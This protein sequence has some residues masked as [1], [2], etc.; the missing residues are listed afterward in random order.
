[1]TSTRFAVPLSAAL[2]ELSLAQEVPD[3]R[4]LDTMIRRYPE[5]SE[6]LTEFAIGLA[7]NSLLDQTE[8]E[9]CESVAESDELNAW[10][11]RAMSRFQNRLYSVRMGGTDPRVEASRLQG[12]VPNPFQRLDRVGFR[13]LASKLNANTAFVIKLRDRQILPDTVPDG[14]R[15][16]VE[17]ELDIPEG[18][19][20]GHLSA[21]S[22]LSL[23][24]QFFKAQNKPTFDIKQSFADAVRTSGLTNEQQDILLSL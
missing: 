12:D 19:F 21:Q 13:D 10:V 11:S 24:P 23:S 8:E 17:S 6:Q 7:L 15:R 5:H 14:F 18:A 3:A 9:A 4:L 22:H 1:M 20:V 2:Y 16:L